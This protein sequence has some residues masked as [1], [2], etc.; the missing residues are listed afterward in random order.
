MDRGISLCLFS[1]YNRS[2]FGIWDV[3]RKQRPEPFWNMGRKKKTKSELDPS[4]QERQ[5]W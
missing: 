4:E 1:T 5:N 2:R 3:K